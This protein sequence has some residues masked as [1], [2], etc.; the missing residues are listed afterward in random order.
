MQCPGFAV[1]TIE[2][3]LLGSLPGRGGHPC[4]SL[5]VAHPGK[6]EIRP[7]ADLHAVISQLST[8]ETKCI[9]TPE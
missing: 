8:P 5:N 9:G 6:D 2:P 1:Q 7:Q 4:C 3:L